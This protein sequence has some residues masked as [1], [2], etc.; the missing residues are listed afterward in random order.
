MMVLH[1]PLFAFY[2]RGGPGPPNQNDLPLRS[3]TLDEERAGIWSNVACARLPP[4]TLSAAEPRKASQRRTG[5]RQCGSRIRS[6]TN[7]FSDR[8]PSNAGKKC[9]SEPRQGESPGFGTKTAPRVMA[10]EGGYAAALPFRR[11]RSQRVDEYNRDL[12][13]QRRAAHDK[14]HAALVQLS[15]STSSPASWAAFATSIPPPT[16]DW[17]ARARPARSLARNSAHESVRSGT[18]NLKRSSCSTS[19]PIGAIVE[20]SARRKSSLEADSPP[21]VKS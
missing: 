21:A 15:S 10:V 8:T 9:G 14:T 18:S 6:K 5:R 3:R 2:L 4:Q 1:R 7:P 16:M 19:F 12:D 11:S 17:K 13:L 20:T